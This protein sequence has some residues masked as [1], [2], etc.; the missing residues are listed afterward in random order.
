MTPLYTLA[1]ISGVFLAFGALPQA[2]KI[3][4]K[5]SARDVAVT[6]YLI[7]AIGGVIWILYGFEI[8][9]FPIIL[10]NFIGV[11]ISIVVLVGWFLY[12]RTRS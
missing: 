6:T 11:V 12:G 4:R 1:L 7:T 3:F 9:N 2:I 8:Q 5:R 10:A